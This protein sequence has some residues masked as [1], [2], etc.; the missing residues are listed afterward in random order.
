MKINIHRGKICDIYLATFNS[1]LLNNI[2]FN[3]VY[4]LKWKQNILIY[5]L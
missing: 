1:K 4:L 3:K 2:L 5:D